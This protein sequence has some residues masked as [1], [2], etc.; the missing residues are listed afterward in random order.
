M[1]NRK[2]IPAFFLFAAMSVLVTASIALAHSRPVRFDP[3]EGAVLTTSPAQVTGWFTSDIRRDPNW[4]FLHVTDSNGNRVDTGPVALSSDRRQ[5]G[6]DLMPNLPAGTYKVTWRTFDDLDGAIF[7]DC[8]NFFIGQAAADDAAKNQLR[9]DSGGKCERI[10]IEAKNGTPVP[11]ITPEAAASQQEEAAPTE[12][13]GATSVSSRGVATWVAAVVGVVG[14]VGGL[15]IG[16]FVLSGRRP[17]A[18]I[19]RVPR[20]SRRRSRR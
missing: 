14:L 5:M 11:G 1:N 20:A 4:S 9:L 12:E 2:W 15:G 10:D 6:V 18:G 13:V 19:P 17:D 8:Y 3:P 7:G 16:R